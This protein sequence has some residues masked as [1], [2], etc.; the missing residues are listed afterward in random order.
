MP[1]KNF[2]KKVSH[3]DDEGQEDDDVVVVDD[4]GGGGVEGVVAVDGIAFR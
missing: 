4:D 3:D 1:Q 2:V